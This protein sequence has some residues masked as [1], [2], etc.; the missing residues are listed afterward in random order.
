MTRVTLYQIFG[1]RALYDL[2]DGSL[3][4]E[5][6]GTYDGVLPIYSAEAFLNAII[7]ET[8]TECTVLMKTVP[9]DKICW[10]DDE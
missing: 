1:V 2:S 6:I 7:E 3:S 8:D 9:E 4:E 5:P 10:G